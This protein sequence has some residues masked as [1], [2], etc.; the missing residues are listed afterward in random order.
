MIGSTLVRELMVPLTEY[1][2]VSKDATLREA[3]LALEDAQNRFHKNRYPHRA[4]LVVDDTGRVI[5]KLSQLDV[6]KALEKPYREIT[7]FNRT[8]RFGLSSGYVK[9]IVDSF[10]PWQRP[11]DDLFRKVGQVRIEQVMYTPAGGEYVREDVSVDE[12]INQL[13]SGRH[14]SLLV[15]RDQEVVGILRL[16]DVFTSICELI[17]CSHA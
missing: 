9:S 17:K 6:L 11:L 12:A 2:K 16:S 5:G 14:Q 7:Q 15:T 8:E 1:A 4:V 3:I 13:V 10:E